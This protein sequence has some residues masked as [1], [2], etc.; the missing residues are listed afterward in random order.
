VLDVVHRQ[1]RI[2]DEEILSALD[3]FYALISNTRVIKQL[4]ESLKSEPALLLGHI[5]REYERS[6][7]C[8]PDHRLLLGGFLGEDSLKVLVEAGLVTRE[9]GQYS[10]YCYTPTAAGKEQYKTLKTSGFF[11]D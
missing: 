6:G 8:V 11:R 7:E 5:N 1:R 3:D 4:L 10:I 9:P 2:G